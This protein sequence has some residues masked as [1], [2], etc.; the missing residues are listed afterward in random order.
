MKSVSVQ[1]TNFY[2]T[3]M[4]TQFISEVMSLKTNKQTKRKKQAYPQ[5][6]KDFS[7]CKYGSLYEA[8]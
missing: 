8:R 3:F 7:N 5:E 6:N 1:I 4:L 2:G